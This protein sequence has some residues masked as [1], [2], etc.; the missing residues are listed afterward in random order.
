MTQLLRLL[1][2]LLSWQCTVLTGLLSHILLLMATQRILW[3]GCWHLDNDIGRFADYVSLESFLGI[4]SVGDGTDEP[5]GV[6]DR[7]GAFD[8]VAV[9]NFLAVLVVC[10]FVIFHIEAEL[11]IWVGILYA[12]D[13][14]QVKWIYISQN[15]QLSKWARE[16]EEGV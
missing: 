5:I 10:E 7:I 8:L 14:N 2:L 3:S 15:T 16:G 9:P 11:I 4:C 13:G 12:K 6:N 1:L